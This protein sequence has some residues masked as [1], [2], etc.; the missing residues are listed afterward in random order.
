MICRAPAILRVRG[1][2]PKNLE[3]NEVPPETHYSERV[4]MDLSN[5]VPGAMLD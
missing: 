3:L 5:T 4:E 1:F 2:T